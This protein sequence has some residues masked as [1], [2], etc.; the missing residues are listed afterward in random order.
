MLSHVEKMLR[1]EKNVPMLQGGDVRVCIAYSETY[2]E[3]E[4]IV[5]DA[6]EHDKVGC[7]WPGHLF[8]MRQCG[9]ALWLPKRPPTV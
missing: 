7:T 3:V 9:A 6:P 2:N 8:F 4:N 5:K 1:V